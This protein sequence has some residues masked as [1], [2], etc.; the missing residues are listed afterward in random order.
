MALTFLS[1]ILDTI[2]NRGDFRNTLKFPNSFLAREAQAAF[3]EAYQLIAETNQGYFDTYATITTSAT[4]DFVALPRDGWAIRAIDR[5]DNGVPCPMDSVGIDCRNNYG[6][7][8]GKPRAFRLTGRG[9][10]LYP[11]PDAAYSLRV[12]YTPSAP[13]LT[14]LSIVAASA[15]AI[16]STGGGFDVTVSTSSLTQS[17]DTM[18]WV[19]VSDSGF[20]QAPIGWFTDVSL[21]T[22]GAGINVF[23]LR[24]I[25]D[26]SESSTYTLTTG[27]DA[28]SVILTYRNLNPF[29]AIVDSD[30]VDVTAS[31][32]Y[33][34]PSLA[35]SDSD[36]YIGIA[37]S[38]S[39]A[40]SNFTAPFT[41]TKQIDV[42]ESTTRI[43]IFD[44]LPELNGNTSIYTARAEDSFTGIAASFALTVN[45][46][47]DFAN[48]WEEY[49]IYG[50]LLRLSS[51][52]ETQ[53]SDWI[54]AQDRAR[55][56]MI[57]GAAQRRSS[58]PQLIPLL[59]DY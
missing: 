9:V 20:G 47:R 37:C 3:S 24:R 59:D 46:C 51:Q 34:C 19:V 36:L 10:D 39:A 18:L 35:I 44:V 25:A 15:A 28:S 2:R 42:T 21:T 40:T 58:T 13:S 49:V 54:A 41:T 32:L 53:R 12:L 52:E 56:L 4:S 57:K 8:R 17:G 26:G 33:P 43:C 5:M 48:G 29:V 22:T 6:I 14:S 31:V 45:P 30:A 27:S 38:T 55:A 11:S 23:V 1:T 16:Q 50:A 7:A